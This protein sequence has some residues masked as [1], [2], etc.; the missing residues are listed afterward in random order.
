M[1]LRDKRRR[2]LN[3][4]G[5]GPRS[6]A[7][8]PARGTSEK[9]KD[10]L[11]DGLF[12]PKSSQIDEKTS[13][14][15]KIP[16]KAPEKTREKPDISKVAEKSLQKENNP[17]RKYI[18]GDLF[19][20]AS[21][22]KPKKKA[23]PVPEEK[24]VPPKPVK[25]EP[26]GKPAVIPPEPPK[27]EKKVERTIID[28][29]VTE[30]PEPEKVVVKKPVI[31]KKRRR[32][33]KLGGTALP[34]PVTKAAKAL[35]SSP[36][37]ELP[38]KIRI[39]KVLMIAAMSVFLGFFVICGVGIGIILGYLQELPPLTSLEN[40]QKQQVTKVYAEDGRT[41]AEFFKQKRIR[42]KLEDIPVYLRQGVVAT[43][44]KSFYDNIGIDPR[45]I[46]RAFVTNM[47]AGKIVEGGSTITQ[48]L[49]KL[50]YTN[51]E[52]TYKRK[53]QDALLAFRIY[54]NYSKDQILE[55]FL[56]QV[57]LGEGAYGIETA[58]ETY[59]GKHARDLNLAECA[60]IA[61]LLNLP[62]KYSFFEN[63]E[64]ARLRRAHVLNR[65][66]AEGYITRDQAKAAKEEPFDLS[67]ARRTRQPVSGYVTERIR[68]MLI[69]DP[70]FGTTAVYSQ[71][72]RVQTTIDYELQIKA[73]ELMAGHLEDLEM[74]R[75][76]YRND[77]GSWRRNVIREGNT[78]FCKIR[79]VRENFLAV[80]I[81]DVNCDLPIPEEAT[82]IKPE[83]I[84]RVDNYVK[85]EV[86]SVN[87]R[88]V[89]VLK[90]IYD[91]PV[92]GAL[93]AIDPYT[94]EIKALIG[95]YDFSI[96][97]FNRAFQAYRQPGS[98]FKP[99]LFAAAF[100]EG[101]NAASIFI[102]KPV[103]YNNKVS[104]EPGQASVLT[105]PSSVRPWSPQNF[106]KE[107][108]GPTS[109]RVAMEHS[110]NVV[111]VRLMEEVGVDPVVNLARRLGI[112]SKGDN[113]LP[114]DLSLALGTGNVSPMEMACAFSAF[115]N[116]GIQISP[117]LIKQVNNVEGDL[118]KR[119]I[120]S[121]TRA[122]SRQTAYLVTNIL[123]Q[124]VKYGTGWN[125]VGQYF[126]RPAAGKTGTTDNYTDA[127][128]IGYTPELVCA[129]WIGFDDNRSL[130]TPSM[131]GTFAAG[132]LWRKFMEAATKDLPER[133]FVVPP[134]DILV[135]ICTDSE[136][137]ATPICEH[138]R[139]NIA[140]R[141][142]SEPPV[143]DLHVVKENVVE[144]P[145][146]TDPGVFIYEYPNVGETDINKGPLDPSL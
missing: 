109:L 129:V 104:D 31:R 125:T 72:L 82:W 13:Q 57:Y 41:I 38:K 70:D 137:I 26:I 9:P 39:K 12:I 88:G 96:S 2:R 32:Q 15:R 143:C 111:A 91:P 103:I 101:W 130:G 74:T 8:V 5:K 133:D 128:F 21:V 14:V 108:F 25:T 144:T 23:E 19:D 67:R 99:I 110:R 90:M 49:A 120:T 77:I 11:K 127:W 40:F 114:R 121:E 7:N 66:V 135:D 3:L 100:D 20:I 126:H 4:T 46:L 115:A 35:A 138:V 146:T 68:R 56:N 55:L 89:P 44:D 43:E 17:E 28:A 141:A 18:N 45:G 92:Q 76:N 78:V 112:N 10:R 50:A 94:G 36:L 105:R 27:V 52:R 107:Y 145:E 61:G 84:Y 58:A 37:T 98:A 59:F 6:A 86:V 93:V 48:L 34:P 1:G 117:V 97:R 29:A 54:Q 131:T 122:L 102:D 95:G 65:M 116:G 24:K 85:A 63:P 119:F 47:K 106:E 71:G 139:K 75:Q 30:K 113:R 140:F 42:V 62:S 132:P 123:Q 16:D 142:G 136:M 60:Y 118:L 22:S 83:N 51:Q 73:Q 53:V 81:N 33:L 87:S 64:A 80:S 79:K 124:V 69:E 134:G